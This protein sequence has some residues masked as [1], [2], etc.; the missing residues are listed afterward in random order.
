LQS[1]A[2]VSGAAGSGASRTGGWLVAAL[3]ILFAVQAFTSA[4]Q[5]SNTWDE[6]GHLFCGYAQWKKGADWV[7]PSHPPLARLLAAAPLLFLSLDD[8]LVGVRPFEAAPSSFYTSSL[9]FLFENRVP[10]E[11]LLAGAR[12]VIICLGIVLGLY[13][14]RWARLLYGPKGGLL[15][16]FLY[17]F[18][19]NLLAHARLA[20]TDFPATALAFMSMYHFWSFTRQPEVKRSLV[21][22]LF[23]G[24]SLATKYNTLFVVLP[25]ASWVLGM[26]AG[27]WKRN[28]VAVFPRRIV[29]GVLA[30]ALTAYATLWG[31]YG[32][33]FRGPFHRQHPSPESRYFWEANRP[34]SPQLAAAVE[35]C[36]R[37]GIL[38]DS[39]L[40]GLCRLLTRSREGHQA[41]LLGQV[42]GGGWWYYFLLAFLFK[43]PPSTLVLLIASLLFFPRIKEA[44]WTTLNFFLLPAALVFLATS[45]QHIHIGLRHIL[46]VYP[47][48]LVLTGRLVHYRSQHQ[49]LGRWILAFLCIWTMWEAASIYP[50]YLAY[51]NGLVGGSQGGRHVLVDSNLDWGQDL[52]G[53]KA[54]MERHGIRKIKLGYFGMSDPAYYGIEYELLPSYAIKDRPLCRAEDPQTADLQGPV[55]VSATLLQGLYCPG[56]VYRML[57]L[58]KPKASIGYSIYVFQAS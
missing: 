46:P 1:P 18:S 28:G 17:S 58:R 10:G 13:V 57:R 31:V 2:P 19:P 22:G 30:M 25:M 51:F 37:A 47:L 32:V 43:T 53:L 26:L 52:K 9:A 49:R 20:T 8:R 23:L 14:Y 7:E 4:L 54:Y 42:S 16:L 21:A 39:Y 36:R 41:Y 38:P 24:L 50:H 55:A 48:L 12:G 29:V 34:D 45:L 3:L 6:S 11:H 5:K 35:V 33:P 44:T 56:D 15:A 27:G 40:Y